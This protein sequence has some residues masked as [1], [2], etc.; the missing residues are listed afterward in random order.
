[1]TAEQTT[2]PQKEE[3]QKLDALFWG[4]ALLWAGLV[5]GASSLGYLPEVGQASA[6][7]WVFLGAGLYGLLLSAVRLVLPDYS[8]PTIWDY[9][10]SIVFVLIG[11]SGFIG[12]AGE[13]VFP[14]ILILIG[15]AILAGILLRRA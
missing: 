5:F 4:G 14:L 8:N 12:L 3:R 11:L 10:W 13:L 15:A 1:M 9:V 6:W 7:S 2:T